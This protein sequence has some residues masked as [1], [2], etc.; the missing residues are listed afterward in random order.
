MPNKKNTVKA[1]NLTPVLDIISTTENIRMSNLT[2]V[3]HFRYEQEISKRNDAEN[4]FVMLKKV[5]CVAM[6]ASD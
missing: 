3:C 5:G 4:E 6:M 1:V 2:S